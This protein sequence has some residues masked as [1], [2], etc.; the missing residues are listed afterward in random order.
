[1]AH[2]GHRSKILRRSQGEELVRYKSVTCN[3]PSLTGRLKPQYSFALTHT[4]RFSGGRRGLWQ[5]DAF[6]C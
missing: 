5:A 3:E 1:M 2:V 4:G 6:T